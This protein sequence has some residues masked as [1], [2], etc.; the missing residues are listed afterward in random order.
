MAIQCWPALQADAVERLDGDTLLLS[1]DNVKVLHLAGSAVR[2]SQL[3][4]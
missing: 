2:K 3:W 4:L 1:V